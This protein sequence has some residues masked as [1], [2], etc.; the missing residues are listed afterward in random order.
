MTYIIDY[1]VVSPAVLASIIENQVSNAIPMW[2]DAHGDYFEISIA[3]WD[4]DAVTSAD[5]AQIE[6]IMAPYI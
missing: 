1:A 2:H 6:R 5:L 3:W 4:E